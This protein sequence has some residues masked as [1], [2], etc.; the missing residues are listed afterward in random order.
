[1]RFVPV[2]IVAAA[3]PL[4]ACSEQDSAG[5]AAATQAANSPAAVVNV[6]SA[7]HYD[8]DAALD[9][10]FLE[11]TGIKVR[12]RD[13]QAD[14]LLALI[15]SEREYSPA[16]VFMTVDAGRLW[17]A[18]EAGILSPVSSDVLD[19][20]VPENLRQEDGLW[21]GFSTRARIIIYNKDVGKPAPLETYADLADPAHR[22]KVCVRS[23]SNIYNIS[24]LASIV[25]HRGAEAAE[26]WTKGVVANFA[27]KPQS[28]DV[29]QIK[30]VASGECGISIINSYYL[31]RLIAAEDPVAASIGVVFPNQETTG[32][33]VNI[34]G[35]GI[36]KY[37]PNRENAVKY[38]EFLTSEDAQNIFANG[39]HEYPVVSSV[40]QTAALAQLGDFKADS[41]NAARL[42]E[43]QAEAVRIFDRAGW[44]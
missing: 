23:S 37:A 4:L 11:L 9:A 13:A 19:A 15:L 12:H 41:L 34:S 24:L 17:R 16:D 7:R 44:P 38:L 31:A 33:H 22:G 6:Y 25:S 26:D 8:T 39:N 43:N 36:P 14:Q 30:A 5:D 18:Q 20:R 32:A 28:N 27:R 1:M 10:K 35:A 2:C 29:G 42:G 21:F 3:L 40:P